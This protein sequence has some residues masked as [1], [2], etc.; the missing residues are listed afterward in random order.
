MARIYGAAFKKYNSD[1]KK[2]TPIKTGEK[3]HR[4]T[5][6]EILPVVNGSPA[7]HICRCECSVV[8]KTSGQQLRKGFIVA[9]KACT[10]LEKKLAPAIAAAKE[11]ERLT[12]RHAIP[13]EELP[14]RPKWEFAGHED[15]LIAEAESDATT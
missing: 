6:L 5:V 15:E 13:E 10:K 14:Q 8:I 7:V 3:F 4:L 11:A 9:C 12:S 1:R 2:Y